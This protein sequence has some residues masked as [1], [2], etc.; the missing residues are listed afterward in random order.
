MFKKISIS[1][2]IVLSMSAC[3]KNTDII[4]KPVETVVV[5]EVE[6]KRQP[7]IIP[8]TDTLKMRDI[9]WIVISKDNAHNKL[10]DGEAYFALD[11]EGYENI[12]KNMNDV[13]TIIQQKDSVIKTYKDYFNK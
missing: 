9:N 13:R 6:V 11:V 10:K 8:R 5:K 3:S 2:C 4:E 1:F 12:S 7:P